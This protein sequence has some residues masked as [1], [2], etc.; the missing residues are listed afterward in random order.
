MAG[1]ASSTA[2][3]V[4]QQA[5][6]QRRQLQSGQSRTVALLT[7]ALMAGFGLVLALVLTSGNPNAAPTCNGQVMSRSDIC[8]IISTDG[9]GGNSPISR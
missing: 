1:Q 7:L 9:G 8:D 5:V 4:I 3:A 6:R 2:S